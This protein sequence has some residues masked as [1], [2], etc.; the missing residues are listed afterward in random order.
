MA[1]RYWSA[2]R[3]ERWLAVACIGAHTVSGALEGT[4][5]LMLVPLLESTGVG[6]GGDNMFTRA[7]ESLGFHDRSLVWA[8]VAGFALM[9]L[10]AA[11]TR[12]AAEVAMFATKARVEAH[13][14]KDLTERMLGMSW[15]SFLMMRF[16]GVAN[17]L[18]MESSQIG[19]GIQYFLGAASAIL[20]TLVYVGVALVLSVQLTLVVLG[21]ALLGLLVLRPMSRRAE[22]HGHEW[23]AAAS[24]IAYQ[25]SDV[26]GNMKF[27][28]STGARD[29]ALKF[30]SRAY[31]EY[32]T[33]FKRSQVSP[34][35]V[36]LGYDLAALTFVVVLLLVSLVGASE[37]SASTL[38]FLAVFMRLSPRVRDLQAGLVSVRVQFP[39]L[40]GWEER[41]SSAEASQAEL[42]GTRSPTFSKSL[43]FDSVSFRFPGTSANVLE[44]VSWHVAPGE[45]VAFVGESGAG[46]TTMLDLVT[47][48][49]APTAGR[50]MLDDVS[51]D[52]V[53]I[54]A[55]QSH[56]GLVLQE[57]P[58]FHG[59]VRANIVGA[60]ELD[61]VLIWD[62]LAAAH[63]KSFVEK[64]PGGLDTLVGERGGR[65]SGGQRQR[66]GLARALYR[67]PWLLIL[68]EATSALDSAGEQVVRAALRDLHA[69][70][71]MLIVAHR[72]ATV[73]IAD[74]IH[75]LDGGRI[76][77]SGSWSELMADGS[78]PFARMA[79]KQG[80]AARLAP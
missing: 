26:L 19:V 25:V 9:S 76:V 4:A 67:R 27:F 8:A 14:R 60:D 40:E 11:L 46:K 78:G 65:L 17:S 52:Q 18:L 72:L 12:Y 3:P 77:Q 57:N 28:R 16:G 70:V 54:E 56:I 71:S 73:E 31:D 15:S 13:L 42:S 79:A 58:L 32:A 62:C 41:R 47:G 75:V 59:T 53:D 63:A 64:L 5:L 66:L 34:L 68:D 10:T 80:L 29:R 38:V 44:E 49:L 22:R 43:R 33:W 7:L 45:A 50:I 61:E 24:E 51:L 23:T 39:W 55:W 35:R 2:I 36:R 6:G 30:F 48:L 69:S 20:V 37:L 1:R 74:R 21:F